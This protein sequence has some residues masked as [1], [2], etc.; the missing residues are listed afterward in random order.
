MSLDGATIGWLKA[1]P[2]PQDGW[3]PNDTAT[4]CDGTYCITLKWIVNSSTF[5]LVTL[6][7]RDAG[8]YKNQPKPALGGAART[9]ST[10]FIL[11][12]H[13]E[14]TDFYQHYEDGTSRLYHTEEMFIVDYVSFNFGPG[15][16]P[17]D[18]NIEQ[19]V[20][21]SPGREALF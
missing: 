17:L 8:A 7:F 2:P 9:A 3:K 16:L 19:I 12:G 5:A 6:P 13:M 1:N 15:T 4:I 11:H 10:S 21:P 18:Q 20:A 14:C